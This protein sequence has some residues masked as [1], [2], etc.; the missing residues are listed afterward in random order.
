MQG[1][2]LDQVTIALRDANQVAPLLPLIKQGVESV[3]LGP[4]ISAKTITS[5]FPGQT[6][7]PPQTQFVRPPP[8]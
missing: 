7:F 8:R 1:L 5:R 6:Q 4:G 2:K 3:I